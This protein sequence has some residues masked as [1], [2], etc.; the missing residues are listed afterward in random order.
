MAS[1]NQICDLVY[2]ALKA[3]TLEKISSLV[4]TISRL[5]VVCMRIP[6]Q[7]KCLTMR[8]HIQVHKRW[9]R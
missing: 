6:N 8:V 5:D 1:L 9:L 2:P 7:H 3:E 4:R